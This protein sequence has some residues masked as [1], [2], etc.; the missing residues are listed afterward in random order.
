MAVLAGIDE[1][2]YGPLLGPLVVTGVAFELADDAIQD[3]LWDRLRTSVTRRSSKR[4]RRLPIFD[5]KRLYQRKDGLATLERTALVMAAAAGVTAGTFRELLAAIAPQTLDHLSSYPWYSGFDVQLPTANDPTAVTMQANA[6]SND[7]R[8][9]G[10]RFIGLFAEPLLEGHFNR[11][12]HNTRNKAVVS[13]GLVLRIAQR[14]ASAT[15]GQQLRVC[16]DRQGGRMRYGPALTTAFECRHLHI[17]AESDA[18][19]A[20]RLDRRNGPHQIEFITSGEE[21]HLPIALASILSKYLRELFMIALNR[22]WR[23]RIEGLKP[24]AGYYQDARRFLADIEPAIR[25]EH[26]QRA[27]LVRDRKCRLTAVPGADRVPRGNGDR[28]S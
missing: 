28:G 8:R 2:G 15:P 16:I 23:D 17:L 21:H 13:M 6:V 27:L 11:L 7:L 9:C 25:S 20:Y 19:S 3:C 1:A 18:R 26:L 12:V 22:Y 14:I 4:D 10:L 24:T 5:S